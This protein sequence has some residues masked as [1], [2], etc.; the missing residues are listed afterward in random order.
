[1]RIKFTGPKF[2]RRSV[3]YYTWSAENNQ[4]VEI[5]DGPLC[6]NLL[7]ANDKFRVTG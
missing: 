6:A 7:T 3:G 2:I 4:V 5:A 1:M